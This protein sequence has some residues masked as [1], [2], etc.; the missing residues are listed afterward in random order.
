M[1]EGIGGTPNPALD[2]YNYQGCADR[3]QLDSYKS[4]LKA[5]DSMSI[6]TL[7]SYTGEAKE[8]I[9]D[10]TSFCD[11]IAPNYLTGNMASLIENVRYLIEQL[12]QK[13]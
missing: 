13:L 1:V 3:F 5:F 9:S 8:L 10:A 2:N 7:S 6:D 4:R 12:K 11:E